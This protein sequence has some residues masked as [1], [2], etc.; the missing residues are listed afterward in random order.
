MRV[1]N[2]LRA[3]GELSG[4][5]S[6]AKS[7]VSQSNALSK[8]INDLN[9]LMKMRKE[10]K[11]KTVDKKLTE[12]NF[13]DRTAKLFK[14][15][16]KAVEKQTENINENLDVLKK[17]L[18]LPSSQQ[19]LSLPPAD[20]Y[21]SIRDHSVFLP[22]SQRENGDILYKLK[23]RDSPQIKYNPEQPNKII[24]FPNDGSQ[25]KEIIISNGTK[26]LL[27]SVH[28]NTSEI[29]TEDI[30]GYFKIYEAIGDKPGG[31]NRITNI[32]K[33]KQ[34]KEALQLVLKNFNKKSRLIPQIKQATLG[35]GLVNSTKKVTQSEDELNKVM[36]RL[37][38]LSSGYKAGHT[39]VLQEMTSILDDLLER[40]IITKKQYREFMN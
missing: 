29:K 35:E 11:A 16:T 31:G 12:L 1:K 33:T 13:F 21:K 28:P 10:L 5:M 25:E 32:I 7:E 27:F 2:E 30:D 24:V 36:K 17:Q 34:N 40:K 26:D 4:A 39:N 6:E 18:S 9:E 8:K 19:Q 38:V 20:I 23:N 3:K 15:I 14:P 37:N 22:H